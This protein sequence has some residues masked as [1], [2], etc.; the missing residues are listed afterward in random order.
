MPTFYVARAEAHGGPRNVVGNGQTLVVHDCASRDAAVALVREV[1]ANPVVLLQASPGTRVV[2]QFQA[3]DEYRL[4]DVTRLDPQGNA[5][6]PADAA[7]PDRPRT[8]QELLAMHPM[9]DVVL[10]RVR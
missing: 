5:L 6:P 10:L 4:A 9:S 2:R 8:I 1:A 7:H 3:Y